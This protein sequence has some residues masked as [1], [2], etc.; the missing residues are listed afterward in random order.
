MKKKYA[1]SLALCLASALVIGS[2]SG[3]GRIRDV[4]AAGNV[5]DSNQ[6]TGTAVTGGAVTGGAITGGAV[7]TATPTP[8]LAPTPKP[9]L[10][11]QAPAAPASVTARGGS[12]RV[13]LTWSKVTGAE[14]YYIYSRPASSASYTR[15]K[16]ITSADTLT[17]DKTSLT[18]NT[19]Y[20][21][22]VS[23]YKNVGGTVVES[24]LSSIVSA[25]TVAAKKTTKAAKKYS[26]KAKFTAS[27]AY[28]KYT[29]MKA[30]LN[31]SKTFAIPGMKNTNVGGFNCTSMVPQGITLAGSYFLITAY[32]SKSTDYSV[33][34]VVSRSSKS[35]ITTIILPSKAKV[36][37]IAF[38]GTN[39]W[40]SKG[41]YVASFPYEFITSTVNAGVA[42]KKL[43][44][45][46]TQ[47]KMKST[48]SFMGYYN[49]ILWVGTY[50]T[51]SS[52][53]YGY[54]VGNVSTA[55]TLTQ[56][57][58]MSVPGKTQGITF[59]T[60]GTM[61]LT[62]ASGKN[63]TDSGY[64]SQ[65]RTYRPSYENAG[66]SGKVLKNTALK[67]TKLPPKAEGV[68]IYGTY[69]YALFS[70][71]HYSSCKYPVDRVVALK[72]NKLI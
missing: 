26:T 7:Q 23:A 42:Y 28:K 27:P 11:S 71:S 54:K 46:S 64:I 30:A 39:V 22:Y 55:P 1:R 40:I 59:D 38:D 15:V 67:V 16:T 48:A 43:S 2:V 19:T 45:Y 51:A 24:G 29:K 36:G 60:D 14:G 5:S 52:T 17:Y 12:K 20:Y 10:S 49:G 65:M 33:I 31:Y 50:N 53:M 58:T 9:D 62:R 57:H 35:Y 34:Y 47:T 3:I 18:Q 37:G 8:T 61:I 21:F 70:S 69:T 68:A 4:N 25:T 32:D 63:T 72:T 41:G 56:T 44:A 6:S 13:R 66:A